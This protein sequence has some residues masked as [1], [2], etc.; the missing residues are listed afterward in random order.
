MKKL[1]TLLAA[2][3]LTASAFAQAPE[4]MSYQAVVRD[5]GNALVT[6]QAVGMQ[7]IILQGFTSGTAVYV[8]TQTPNTNINGL[9]SI[10]IGSGTVVSGA[11]NTIDWSD[12]PYFIKTETDPTGGTNY[13]ITGSSELMSVPYAIHAN[14][15]DSIVGGDTDTQLDSVGVTNLGFVAGAHTVDTDT[16]LDST[17]VAALGYVAGAHT[18]DTDTQL[19]STGVTNLG[20]VAGAHTVDTDTQLDSTGVAALGYVAGALTSYTETDPIYGASVASGITGV[21]TTNWNTK[22]WGVNG[23]NIYST[24]GNIGIGHDNPLSKI[25]LRDT[26]TGTKYKSLRMNIVGGNNSASYYSGLDVVIVGSNGDNKAIVGGS[27]GTSLGENRGVS[28]YASNGYDNVG[29]LGTATTS[30]TNTNGFNI[31]LNGFARNSVFSNIAVGAYAEGGATSN[32]VSIGVVAQAT[33]TT[34]AGTNYGIYAEGSNGATNYAG[35]FVGDVTVTGTFVNP[36]DA[37]FKKDVKQINSALSTI[38]LLNPVQYNFKADYIKSL[39]LPSNHQYG[40]I[41]Q[42]LKLVLPDLVHTQK[43]PAS[44]TLGSSIDAEKGKKEEREEITFEGV[45]YISLIPI[46][47]KAIKEQDAKI[48]DLENTINELKIA[49]EKLT[50]K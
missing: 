12:G 15:A 41:A 10:E 49:L 47:V 42:E 37:K 23:N 20:F 11:F 13:T 33:S 29:V 26:L 17:G 28:A 36:S 43:A 9:V 46:M 1:Y 5:A 50:A 44:A 25:H 8:E 48:I 32:G 7:I 34:T 21:D 4:K 18:I 40:F 35:Y 24:A 19:D 6:D 45:N 16:Q 3:I 39:N 38:R 22:Q 31:G 27:T 14:T 30:N 2:V